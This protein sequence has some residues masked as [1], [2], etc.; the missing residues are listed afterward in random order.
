MEI[1]RAITTFAFLISQGVVNLNLDNSYYYYYCTI[2][3][4]SFNPFAIEVAAFTVVVLNPFS[5]RSYAY[6]YLGDNLNSLLVAY[7]L[8]G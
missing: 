6:Y 5:Y 7:L 2:D 1:C 4:Y 3:L 8:K